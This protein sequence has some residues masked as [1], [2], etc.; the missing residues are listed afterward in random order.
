[1][2]LQGYAAI[3]ER[4]STAVAAQN[5]ALLRARAGAAPPAT[6]DGQRC[7]PEC[8]RQP[9]AVPSPVQAP[10]LWPPRCLSCLTGLRT[11]RQAGLHPCLP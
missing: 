1:M 11:A 3:K 10:H 8:L 6:C 4:F 7:R 5:A 9:A 2:A